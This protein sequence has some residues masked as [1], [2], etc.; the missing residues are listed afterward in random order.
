MALRKQKVIEEAAFS[1]SKLIREAEELTKFNHKNVVK[2]FGVIKKEKTLFQEYCGKTV[3]S[4]ELH[5]LVG[6]PHTLNETFPIDVKL[7]FFTDITNAL[8]YLHSMKVIVGDLKPAN[9]LVTC[10]LKEDWIFK[11]ADIA[12]ETK[13]RHHSTACFSS[14][15]STKNTFTYTAAFLAPEILMFTS[16]NM[17]V[18]RSAVCDIYSF[19][20][21]MY[22][23]LFL[24][25]PLIEKLHPIQFFIAIANTWRPSIPEILDLKLQKFVE[26][27]SGCWSQDP[28]ARPEA[29][30]LFKTFGGMT[31]TEVHETGKN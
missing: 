27:M 25:A 20:I 14:V 16:G 30:V 10:N 7:K 8:T 11:L 19:G 17:N 4:I 5:S 21:L 23:V 2:T 9:V 31:L 29:G 15:I 18:K 3:N 22:Q 24:T 6:L 28:C 13:N 12:P 1:E 26:L